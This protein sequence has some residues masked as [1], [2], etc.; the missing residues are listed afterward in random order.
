MPYPVTS[1]YV[2]LCSYVVPELPA[3]SARAALA[4]PAA[5]EVLTGA[6]AP[7]AAAAPASV[8]VAGAAAGAAGALTDTGVSGAAELV[9]DPGDTFLGV[10]A[11][12]RSESS[13]LSGSA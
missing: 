10:A 6:P 12:K 3:G 4:S 7:A 2:K 1:F 5:A 9:V 11:A 8:S 13:S